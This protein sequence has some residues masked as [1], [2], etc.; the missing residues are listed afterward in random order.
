MRMTRYLA[1]KQHEKRPNR[2]GQAAVEFALIMVIFL[3]I[4]WGIIEVSRAVFINSEIGNAA[5]EST[6]YLALNSPRGGNLSATATLVVATA[7][8]KGKE[9][10]ALADRNTAVVTV[11]PYT[12]CVFCVVTVTVTYPWSPLIRIPSLP[13]IPLESTAT[14]LIESGTP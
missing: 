5:R 1:S 14:K 12:P 4:V 8:A 13:N 10:L 7:I 6:Q 3:V 9:K 11:P 2:S